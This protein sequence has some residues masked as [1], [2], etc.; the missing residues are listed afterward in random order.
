MGAHL[1]WIARGASVNNRGR[2]HE[3]CLDSVVESFPRR[4]SGELDSKSPLGA[5]TNIA[6]HE[7]PHVEPMPI[8]ASRFCT[9]AASSHS[10]LAIV[11][12]DQD[13]GWH[14]DL[15]ELP[16]DVS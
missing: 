3:I 4:A 7:S 9:V 1:P 2:N 11:I 8:L 6:D 12:V 10:E 5:Q 13:A 14:A 15:V 16:A